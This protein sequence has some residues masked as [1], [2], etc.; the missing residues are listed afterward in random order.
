M[1]EVIGDAGA[2]FSPT[3]ID[4]IRDA[5]ERTVYS[6]DALHLLTQKGVIQLKKFSWQK[7]AEETLNIY[8]STGGR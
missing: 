7:C 6:D 2:Y 1:P 3:N 5:I 8:T 4:D